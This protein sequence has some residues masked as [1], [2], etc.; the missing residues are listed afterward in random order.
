[1]AEHLPFA[2]VLTVVAVGF[3]RIAFQHWREGTAWLGL[4]LLLGAGLRALLPQDRVGLLAIRG[5]TADI[6][7]YGVLGVVVLLVSL[8]IT[9]G[10]LSSH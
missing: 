9:G 10:P 5:R 2:L 8:T 6:G 3:G 4:A 1:M 7:C